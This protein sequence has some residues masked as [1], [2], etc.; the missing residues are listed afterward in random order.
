MILAQVR[1]DNPQLFRTESSWINVMRFKID[2]KFLDELR[3]LNKSYPKIYPIRT[4]KRAAEM[5]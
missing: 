2:R 5:F 3:A 1:V 4:A